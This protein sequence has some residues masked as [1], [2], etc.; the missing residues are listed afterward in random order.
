MKKVLV[1]TEF[2]YLSSCALN[3]GL[4]IA[5][6]ANASINVVSVIEPNYNEF[7]EEYETYSYDPTSTLKNIQITEE[8]RE[9]MHE[10]AEE[11]SKWFPDQEIFPKI[12]YGKKTESLK[13]EIREQLIDLVIMGGDLFDPEDKKSNSIL[14]NADAPVVIL[15]CMINGLEKFRDIIL[16]MDFDQDSS[17]LIEHLKSLQELLKAKIH[18]VRVNKPKSALSPQKCEESLESYSAKHMLQNFKTVSIDATTEMEGLLS[19]C[20][21]IDNAFVALGVHK[22]SFLGKLITNQNAAEEIIA[23]SVHPVWTFKS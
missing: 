15:K 11:I 3:L 10:R 12:I 21:T 13:K 22:R 1:P 18:V 2:T 7:M 20:D 16:L 23:N 6:Q 9:R 8:A 17:D 14:Y 5:K 4:Q 19:Y